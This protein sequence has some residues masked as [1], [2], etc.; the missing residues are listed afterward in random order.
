MAAILKAGAKGADEI[1]LAGLKAGG[2]DLIGAGL[3]NMDFGDLAKN[4][5]F[6]D[7]AKNMDFGDLAKQ[8][9]VGDLAKQMDVGD[10]AK[11]MD[12][13]DLAKQADL[14]DLAKQADLGDLAKQ[15]DLGDAAKQLD[16]VADLSKQ[17]DINANIVGDAARNN[18]DK[19]QDLFKGFGE[20]FDTIGK[21]LDDFAKYLPTESL[22][23]VKTIVKNN[24]GKTLGAAVLLGLGITGV[25]MALEAFNKNNNKKVGIIRSYKSDDS[26]IF[27]FMSTTQD[28]IIEFTPKAKIVSGDKVEILDS[29]FSPDINNNTYDIKQIISDS[30]IMISVPKISTFATKGTLT[31]KTTQENHFINTFKEGSQ[32]AGSTVGAVVGA[33]VTT[34]VGVTGGVTGGL[35]SGVGSGLLGEY[36]DYVKYVIY[37]IIFIICLGVIYKIYS[38][39]TA[40]S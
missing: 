29:D 17:M 4:M 9:D 40:F 31:I 28:I 26:G 20:S 5:D 35:L 22:D 12:V 2:D 18:L 1:A 16:D 39:S 21:K 10:I 11:Q 14:G 25:T 6:G 24:P 8:M 15:A 36:Y 37:C 19:L 7:L 23:K 33:T 38:L 34:A 13:G 30:I 32:K 3:K 27:S